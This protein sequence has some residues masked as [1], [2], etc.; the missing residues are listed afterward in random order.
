MSDQTNRICQSDFWNGRLNESRLG[1]YVYAL[2]DP[3]SGAVFYVGLA[4]GLAGA[5]NQ[6][7]QSHLIETSRRHA[8]AEPLTDKQQR[9]ADIWASGNEVDLLILR[10]KMAT[11]EE[12]NHVEAVAID[13]LR[14]IQSLSPLTNKLPGH[15]KSEHAIV[16]AN[17][18]AEILAEPVN[19]SRAIES[20]WLFNISKALAQGRSPFEATVAAWRVARKDRLCGYAVGLSNGVSKVVIKIDSWQDSSKYAGKCE[21]KGSVA[22]ETAAGAELLEKDYSAIVSKLGYWQ[23]GNPIRINFT[24]GRAD[25]VR[26]SRQASRLNLGR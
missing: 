20:V 5:G 19:P 16:T 24:C 10:R 25:I 1:N 21:I 17:T 11:R 4:G 23:R 3:R 13:L 12:A 2:V 6:R 7:P 18:R 8:K 22:N 14:T 9:I 26:G 15:G